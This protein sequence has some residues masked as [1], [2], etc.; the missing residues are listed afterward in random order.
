[1]GI[2]KYIDEIRHNFHVYGLLNGE[3]EEFVKEIDYTA[4]V[5]KR[6]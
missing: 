3:W 4:F 5:V 6:K 1:M 2:A